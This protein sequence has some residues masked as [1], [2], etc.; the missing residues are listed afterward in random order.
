L[1]SSKALGKPLVE[2]ETLGWEHPK[3]NFENVFEKLGGSIYPTGMFSKVVLDK[4]RKKEVG[5]FTKRHW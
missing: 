5:G 4:W 1:I 2:P 3:R